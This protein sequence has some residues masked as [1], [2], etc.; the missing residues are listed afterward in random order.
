M[1]STS[2]NH[3]FVLHLPNHSSNGVDIYIILIYLN[4]NIIGSAN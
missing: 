3:E 2:G 1:A 4:I